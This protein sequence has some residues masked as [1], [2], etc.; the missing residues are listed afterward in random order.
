MSQ[1]QPVFIEPFDLYLFGKGEH[2]D[3]Y[4]ILGA[5]PHEQN[6]ARGY[7]FAVWAPNARK[8]SLVGPFND[9]LGREHPLY[10]VGSSGIWAGFLPGLPEG[11]LYK[12]AVKALDG[13]VTYKTDPLAFATELRPGNASRTTHL[14]GYEWGDA[15][16]L[17]KRA[18][19]NPPLNKPQSVYE[20]HAGSWRRRDGHF[21][22]YRELA[23]ELIPYVKKLGFSH[24][25]FMPLSEHPLDESWGY[26]TSHYFAP[27][28][29]FGDPDGLR[30]LIDRCHQEGVGIILDWVP[31]HFPKDEWCLGRFD[32]TA[33]YE[34]ED[35]RKGEHPDW[36][37]YIFNY[38]RHEVKNF[39][40]A[41]ALYWFKEFHIDGIRIDAVA[42]ML[43][44]DYSRSDGQWIH[45]EFGGREKTRLC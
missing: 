17:A 29:R 36:G 3:L 9:W 41:N 39:L 32:G 10:P 20:V 45:N 23:D 21:L 26:Q 11:E 38:G 8:V 6:G 35:P 16:W 31:G 14:E 33:L 42:S 15:D 4:R 13:R 18:A 5:H 1:T 37:T 34:H 30:L 7:R 25:E 24:I 27:T 40:L 12:F 22:T 2:W 19:A 28:S 43:Y 44:L